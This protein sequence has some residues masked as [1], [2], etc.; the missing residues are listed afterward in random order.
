MA[1]FAPQ[2][3]AEGKV[4]GDVAPWQSTPA[5]IAQ[6]RRAVRLLIF[7]QIFGSFGMGA[8]A[9][10][11]VLLV[12]SVIDSEALAGLARTSLTLGA[13]LLG[14]PLAYLAA[15]K[16]RRISLSVGWLLGAMGSASLILAAIA[17]NPVLVIA[18]M[19]LFGAGTAAGLQTRFSA[20]DLAL[21]A[22]R[23]R[24]LSIVVWSSMFGSVLGPNL[25]VPGEY[26]A[27]WL[28]LPPLAGAF[29]IAATML[30]IAGLILFVWL[31]PD[32]LLTAQSHQAV[33]VGNPGAKKRGS[34]P[35]VLS[36]IWK[37][38]VA[39][40]A[41]IAVVVSHVSMVSLMTMTPVHMQHNGASISII[42]IT[43]SIHVLGMFA[44]APIV[45]YASDKLGPTTVIIGGQVIFVGSALTVILLG[46]D[47]IHMMVTLFLLGLGWSCG[48]VPGSILVSSSV[49]PEIRVPT[50]GVVDTLMNSIAALAA[51]ASGPAFVL[52]GFEGLAAGVVI[53]AALVGAVAFTLPRSVWRPVR[54]T[55]A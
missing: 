14:V 7:A 23:G 52:L 43:I 19:T 25:G 16:G 47:T 48:T 4:E 12:E 8:S 44:F 10:V 39:R 55:A 3:D 21:P 17:S 45:G 36:T 26:V 42:G 13:A 34:F 53:L 29:V 2:N 24:T 30:L 35:L 54:P 18:G 28:G 49:P 46:Q 6:Q 50:Q 38:P 1:S 31:R 11:G 33:V 51:F 5:I 37:L 27:R 9:S 20:T 41:L 40:F 22:R 15:N 32:P